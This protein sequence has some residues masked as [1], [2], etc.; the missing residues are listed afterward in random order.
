VGNK[1]IDNDRLDAKLSDLSP[2]KVLR[3]V[4]ETVTPPPE[5]KAR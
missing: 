5:R 3:K 1:R 2:G 4:R